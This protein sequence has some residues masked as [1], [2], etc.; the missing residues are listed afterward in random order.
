MSAAQFLQTNFTTQDPATYKSAID[1]NFAVLSRLAGKFAAHAQA[2]PDMTVAVDAGH[3]FSGSTITE[4]PAQ[5]SPV[6]VAPIANSRIDRVVIDNQTGAC[7]VVTGTEAAVPAAPAIP[8]GKMPV[9]RVALA[10]GVAAITNSMLTDERASGSGGGFGAAGVIASAATCDLGTVGSHNAVI[11]GTTTITSFGASASIAAPLYFIEFSG[12]CTVTNGSNIICPASRDLAAQSGD[13]A[14]VEYLGSGAWRVR[15]FYPAAGIAT[16]AQ[17]AK[18]D[19]ASQFTIFENI[20][21]TSG[22]TID[23]TGIP[24]NT[25]RITINF[26]GV[27]R[28]GASYPLI[29]LGAGSVDTNGYICASTGLGGSG[30][31]TF[32]FTNGFGVAN[33][34]ASNL[35]YGSV[36][37]NR[38][39]SSTFEWTIGGTLYVTNATNPIS[40][41]KTL[42]GILDR[43]RLTTLSGTGAF[44]GGEISVIC[45]G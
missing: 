19:T 32:T 10:V 26:F 37:L 35:I 24:A 12:A 33:T 5:A 28:A 16:A 29:Q 15:E 13:T 30:S 4:V 41:A 42:T 34:S 6:I 2:A 18:A 36:V 38:V 31:S 3:I 40:G 17:G 23:V 7:S 20:A 43:I 44:N 11:S 14:L 25:K 22:T 45:E 1:G 21:T 27:S 39:N 8:S 9:A